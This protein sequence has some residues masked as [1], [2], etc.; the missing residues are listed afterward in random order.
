MISLAFVASSFMVTE[1]NVLLEMDLSG[2]FVFIRMF[3]L[4]LKELAFIF[5]F[6]VTAAGV[7]LSGGPKK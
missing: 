5:S 4:L 2:P 3:S 1:E 6:V 7:V